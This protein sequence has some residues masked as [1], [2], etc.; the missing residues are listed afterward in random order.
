MKETLTT[1]LKQ[2]Y[3]IQDKILLVY[4]TKLDS[5]W[6]DR[7]FYLDEKYNA[8]KPYNHRSMLNCEVVFEYD[9]D[10]KAENKRLIDKVAE[11]L[12]ADNIT[13][14]KWS[15]GNKST[16]LHCLFDYRDV[17]NLE[18]LKRTI[19]RY[20]TEG[21]PLPDMRLSVENHLIRAEYGVHEATGNHKELIS[22]SGKLTKS[23]LPQKVWD[24]Y[25]T[26]LKRGMSI[27]VSKNTNN[28]VIDSEEFKF[29]LNPRSLQLVE[30][31]RERTLFMLIH[32]L[33]DKYK[34]DKKGLVKFLQDWY[35]YAGGFKI[36][37]QEIERKV[38]C[39]WKKEYNITM[40]YVKNLIEE[41][42]ADKILRG[43]QNDEGK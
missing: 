21:L 28:P 41:I 15:S 12:N 24:I 4:R 29:L 7:C 18:L 11:K 9:L 14:R 2:Y 13:W 39:H 3:D 17:A 38:N 36:S 35:K 33:K 42:G 26:M 16:H 30:D 43:K 10:D 20:Y 8:I 25:I 32:L 19:L 5:P 31:G 37:P 34:D 27:S 1:Y 23:R 40:K 22:T 6:T